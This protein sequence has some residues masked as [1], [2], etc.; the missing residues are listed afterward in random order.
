[1]PPRRCLWRAGR[2]VRAFIRIIK[3]ARAAQ[4]RPASVAPAGGAPPP[5]APPGDP[6]PQPEI[7]PL[8][9]A[10]ARDAAHVAAADGRHAPADAG[11]VSALAAR[12]A[13]LERELADSERTH[14]LRCARAP[15]Q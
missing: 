7:E 8:P 15:R 3:R 4:E 6:A 1:M 10:S 5:P 13:L 12:V 11:R 2:A 9:A 14:A